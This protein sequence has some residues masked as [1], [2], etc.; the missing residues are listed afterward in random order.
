MN[1]NL[2]FLHECYETGKRGALLEGS[3]RA[4]K[5][6]S[7]IDFLVW[8]CSTQD[9]LVII[10]IK[11]TLTSFRTTLYQDFNVRLPMF[12]LSSP[13]QDRQTITSFNLFSSRINLLGADDPAKLHGAGS[14][15]V[16]GNEFLDLPQSVFDQLEMRCRKFWW[17]DYNPKATDHWVFNSVEPRQDVGLIR[18]TYKDNPFLSSA[19][20]KKIE[21]Y[22]PNE[23]NIAQGTADSY[24]WNV[25]GLGLR[26]APEGLIFQH[27]TW[28][29]E[30]PKDIDRVYYGSDIGQTAPSTVVKIGV[31][32]SNLFVECLGYMPTESTNDYVDLVG[33]CVTK[34]DIVWA[35]S[36]APGFIASCQ[37]AGY[38]MHAIKKF[39]GSRKFAIGLIKSRKLHIVKNR[40]YHSVNKE[41]C[42]FKYR[43]VNGIKLDEPI[44]GHDHFWDATFYATLANVR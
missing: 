38:A 6:I 11:E 21:S 16:W 44:D 13:F 12:G 36:A 5:T 30:F 43:Q 40:H 17:G 25:Y 42:N 14:D 28:V 37:R 10:I 22:E 7:A 8:L 33:T 15:F 29:D 31:N 32:G 23:I 27:V 4:G 35:D 2:K 39:P 26:S 3:S 9:S 19:E 34:K 24:M 1:P 20:R 41:V 18:T